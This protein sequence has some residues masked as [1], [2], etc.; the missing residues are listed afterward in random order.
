MSGS[1]QVRVCVCVCVCVWCRSLLD[2]LEK[3][4]VLVDPSSAKD[5]GVA[6]CVYG[7]VCV[8]VRV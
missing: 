3:S 6:V 8:R 5:T 4:D 7:C 2:A 1:S